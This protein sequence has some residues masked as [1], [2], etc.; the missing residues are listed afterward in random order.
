MNDLVLGARVEWDV[1]FHGQDLY[2]PLI[3]PVEVRRRI[4]MVFQKPNP[5]RGRGRRGFQRLLNRDVRTAPA[6]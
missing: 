5:S 2:G 6:S 3:D 1:E 4:G